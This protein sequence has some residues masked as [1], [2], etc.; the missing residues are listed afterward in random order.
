MDGMAGERR[1]PVSSQALKQYLLRVVSRSS[2]PRPGPTPPVF[3]RYTIQAQRAVRA[4]V[5]VASLLEHP[6]VEPLH[7]LLGCLHVPGSLA[8]R[9]LEAELAPSEMGTIGAAMDRACLYGRS[10][11]HQA[12]GIFTDRARR[13]VAR[14]ALSYAYR[15]DHPAIGTGHLLLATLD[16]ED[17]TID[18][19]V[20]SGVMG[21]E[22]VHDRLARSVIRALPGDEQ[23]IGRVDDGGVITFDLL[24][25]TL[26]AWFRN[27]LP[28]G[29]EIRGSGRSGGFRLRVPDSRSE[30]DVAIDMSWIVASDQ[31]GRQ[32]LLAVTHHALSSLQI[33]VATATAINW[34]ARTR[35]DVRPEPHAEIAGDT[36]NPTLRLWYGPSHAPVLELTPPILLNMILHE[37]G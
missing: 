17:R 29:W 12:T 20:G 33:A 37:R 35:D 13:L 23:L 27:Q 26:T 2:A 16:A 36:V 3:E 18:R 1:P 10:P 24:I 8:A 9:V 31:P 19:I 25:R 34:P 28:P 30:E 7:L 32:R 15:H 6:D 5:E 11:A 14:D 22:P 21:S 4:G